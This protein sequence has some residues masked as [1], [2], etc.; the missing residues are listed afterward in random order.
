[1]T[2]NW[3]ELIVKNIQPPTTMDEAIDRL[4]CVL[5]DKQKIML[6]AMPKEDL[7]ILHFSL[8]AAIRNAFG[9]HKPGSALLADCG[10]SHPDDA[11]DLIIRKLW[12]NLGYPD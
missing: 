10:V 5:E 11:A 12:E 6:A 7:I 8:G 9:L 1:V 4:M 2:K 3:L